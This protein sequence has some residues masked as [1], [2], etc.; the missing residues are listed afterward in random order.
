MEV[1]ENS[2]SSSHARARGKEKRAGSSDSKGLEEWPSRAGIQ[3]WGL[4]VSAGAS[5]AQGMDP[6]TWNSSLRRR[7]PW[8]GLVS[9]GG[10]N[11]GNQNPLS[12]TG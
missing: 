7:G 10:M 1:T 8:L 3:M 12:S 11:G 5:G 6:P 2:G 4:P 9:R